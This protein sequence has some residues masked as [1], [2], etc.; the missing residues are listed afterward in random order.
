MPPSIS[1]S[2]IQFSTASYSAGRDLGVF[3]DL[4]AAADGH[5]QEEVERLAAQ[6]LRQLQRLGH[7]VDVV[8]RDGRID[9]ER[10]ARPA[11]VLDPLERA[12]ERA[13]AAENVVRGRIGAVE[14]DAHAADARG[15]DPP[16]DIGID[17]RG[18]RRQRDD[19]PAVG[20]VGGNVVDV[21]PEQR[22]AAREDE[23]RGAAAPARLRSGRPGRA[24]PAS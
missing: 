1:A 12:V 16:R 9:L 19:Q 6:V 15:L 17:Q 22:L 8:A 18:V 4:D 13:L 10:D 21:G 3:G 5:E 14:A 2:Y 7:L 11:Q 24:T 20:G 23:D